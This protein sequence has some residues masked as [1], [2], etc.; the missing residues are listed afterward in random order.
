MMSNESLVH[1]G[2]FALSLLA[3][4]LVPLVP[5]TLGPRAAAASPSSAGFSITVTAD[6]EGIVAKCDRGCSWLEARASYEAGVYHL[7]ADGISRNPPGEPGFWFRLTT[8]K[9]GISAI[10]EQGCAWKTATTGFPGA[11]RFT[12]EG[13]EPVRPAS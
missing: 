5:G 11:A 4:V 6:G 12:D 9:D 1:R 2:R 3:A 8:S 13:V 10:C 7:T